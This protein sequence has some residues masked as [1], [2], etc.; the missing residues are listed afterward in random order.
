MSNLPLPRLNKKRNLPLPRLNKKRK[1]KKKVDE[2]TKEL[3]NKILHKELEKHRKSANFIKQDKITVG[4]VQGLI[5]A[6]TKINNIKG[7]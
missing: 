1:T 2:E 4:V 5:I 3:F 7:D 6:L